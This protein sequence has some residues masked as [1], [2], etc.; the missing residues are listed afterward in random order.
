MGAVLGAARAIGANLQLLARLLTTLDLNALLQVSDNTLREIQ[1]IVRRSMVEYVRGAAWRSEG[2]SPPDLARLPSGGRGF[3]F[4]WTDE[5]ALRWE[6]GVR[7]D[8]RTS[9]S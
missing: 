6:V 1:K 4:P 9:A 7:G 8:S 2:V 3:L 5:S